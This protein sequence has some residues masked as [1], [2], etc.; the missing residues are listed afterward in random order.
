MLIL[1]IL[2]LPFVPL[3][4]NALCTWR[5]DVRNIRSPLRPCVQFC[6]FHLFF[7]QG[8][9]KSHLDHELPYSDFELKT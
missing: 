2:A 3:R 1:V 7:P 9:V 5:V 4:E 8:A 6:L